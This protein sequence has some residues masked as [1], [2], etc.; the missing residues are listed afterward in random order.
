MD[1]HTHDSKWNFITTEDCGW[2]CGFT[3]VTAEQSKAF[4]V[5]LFNRCV[6]ANGPSYPSFLEVRWNDPNLSV[7]VGK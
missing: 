6:C 3:F 7:G 2:D 4:H 1:N 5:E